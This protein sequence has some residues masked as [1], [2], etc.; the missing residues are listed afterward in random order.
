MADHAMVTR[1]VQERVKLLDNPLT[2]CIDTPG[3]TAPSVPDVGRHIFSWG[4]D[5]SKDMNLK[6]L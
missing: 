3:I 1:S 4:R 5:D 6:W 2:Y